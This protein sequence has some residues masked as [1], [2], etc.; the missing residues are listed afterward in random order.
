[1]GYP[2]IYPPELIIGSFL[3][4]PIVLWY[5][6]QSLLNQMP[7]PKPQIPFVKHLFLTVYLVNKT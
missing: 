5:I 4:L 2:F 1:M 6:Y 3:I 7:W